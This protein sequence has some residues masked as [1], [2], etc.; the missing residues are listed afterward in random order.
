M[1]WRGPQ[2]P[3]EFPSLGP[4]VGAWIESH[5]IIPDGAMRGA[6]YRLTGEMWRHLVWAY[7]LEPDAEPHPVYPRPVDGLRYH[8][9][10]LRRPQKWGKDPFLAA[11]VA[12]HAFGPVRFA[13]WDATGEPVG[14]EVSTPWIQILGMSEGQTNNTYRPLFRMMTE[15]PLASI[16]GLDVGEAQTKLPSG[17]G[18]IE[19][20]TTSDVS[21]LGNPIDFL[22]VTEPHLM[23]ERNRGLGV[24]RTVRR[25]VRGMGGLWAAATNAWDRSEMS[26]AQLASGA[27]RGDVFLDEVGPDMD[28]VP[29]LTDRGAVMARLKVKY[30]DSARSRGGW[31]DLDSILED[32]V[33]AD[34]GEGEARRFFLDEVVSGSRDAIDGALWAAAARDVRLAPGDPIALGFDGSYNRD[35]TVLIACRI[36]DSALFVLGMWEPPENDPEWVV[37]RREVDDAVVA[38]HATYDVKIGFYD[39]PR[40]QSYIEK[41]SGL[42]PNRV[43]EFPTNS[44]KR[45]DSALERFDIGLRS[46][47]LT[48]A[49]DERLTRHALAAAISEGSLRPGGQLDEDGRPRRYRRLVKKRQGWRIDALVTAVLAASARGHAVGDGALVPREEPA[50]WVAIDL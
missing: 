50:P 16:P 46:G 41:W 49:P 19:R 26:A 31:V 9:A 4:A 36:S 24:W 8:G 37:P 15:G 14:S 42:F 47:E 43:L 11:R 20:V 29:T 2:I 33:A 10:M 25:N 27:R 13:G 22:A 7:R 44:E 39:P 12:A 18:W 23:T 48:Y 45:M 32:A 30:G 3:G 6:P 34:T 21:R 1:P 38:A 35:A 40:W 5:C 28:P 17:D